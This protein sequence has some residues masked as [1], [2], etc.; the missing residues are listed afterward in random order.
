[1]GAEDGNT[2]DFKP[3]DLR[4]WPSADQNPLH[5]GTRPST[6]VSIRPLGKCTFG[7]WRPL[8]LTWHGGQFLN[9]TNTQST[10]KRKIGER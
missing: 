9:I 6:L 1:M 10:A 3:V 5:H 8:K 7:D 2:A 4:I